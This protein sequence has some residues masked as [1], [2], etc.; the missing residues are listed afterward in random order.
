[1]KT[2]ETPHS[3]Q[4]KKIKMKW[5]ERSPQCEGS[6]LEVINGSIKYEI[7]IHIWEKRKTEIRNLKPGL[8]MISKRQK[9]KLRCQADGIYTMDPSLISKKITVS[10][11]KILFK[12]KNF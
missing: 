4:N 8:Q 1:M 11:K 2:P 10:K 5:H 3:S 9:N 7:L 12:N 6:I